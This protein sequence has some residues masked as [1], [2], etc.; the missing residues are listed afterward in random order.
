MTT[1]WQP[2][3]VEQQDDLTPAVLRRLA[4]LF[5]HDGAHWRAGE[6]PPL[7]HWLY[8]LPEAPQ[9]TLGADG[10]PAHGALLPPVDAPRRMWAGGRLT[11]HAALP[12][13]AR[14]VRRSVVT[15]RRVKEGKSGALTFVTVRH[16]IAVGGTVAVTE[17]QDL[18]F[19]QPGPGTPPPAAPDPRTAAARR[20]LT[21]DATTL[22]RFS[23]L[24][25]NAHRIHYD[26]E[27][28]TGAEL[29][30]DLVVHGPLQAMLLADH[31]LRAHPGRPLARF[32]FRGVRPAFVD[33][34]LTL[35][36]AG[37]GTAALWTTDADGCTCMDAQAVL[38]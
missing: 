8:F 13:G 11:F 26:R 32:S 37:D 4:A 15:D 24:T 28:A 25:F 27:Y 10:H 38:G 22:F 36:R 35:H 6:L 29:Y 14:A 33:R 1:D 30:P 31:L 18:V 23:A 12:I 3:T 9:A 17:E 5:D 7:A 16:E 2:V 20:T 34:G 21:P 19:R